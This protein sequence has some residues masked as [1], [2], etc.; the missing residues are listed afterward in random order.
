MRVRRSTPTSSPLWL[1][2]TGVRDGR[3]PS[4]G[5]RYSLCGWGVLRWWGLAVLPTFTDHLSKPDVYSPIL[6]SQSRF[7]KSI[8]RLF[9]QTTLRSWGKRRLQA[10][11]LMSSTPYLATKVT[12]AQ[13]WRLAER[14][15]TNEPETVQCGT[16]GPCSLCRIP[17]YFTVTSLQGTFRVSTFF[18]WLIFRSLISS[19]SYRWHK[20]CLKSLS[21]DT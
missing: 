1:P 16:F 15:P 5:A 20:K 17:V 2:G 13:G 19:F 10:H 11:V 6:K 8:Q 21:C 12:R 18:K 4:R 7:W 9:L 3:A 14:F